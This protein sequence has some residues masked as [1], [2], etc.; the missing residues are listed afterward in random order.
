MSGFYTMFFID[1]ME[2]TNSASPVETTGRRMSG[3]IDL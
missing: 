3:N 1:L 2:H